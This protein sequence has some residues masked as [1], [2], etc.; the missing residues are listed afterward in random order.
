MIRIK[1]GP[2]CYV[3]LRQVDGGPGWLPGIHWQAELWS[4][5]IQ[6]GPAHPFAVVWLTDYRNAAVSG[7]GVMVNYAL[8][9][10]E[11]RRQGYA[12]RLLAALDRHYG[13]ELN[14]GEAISPEGEAL[15][16]SLTR[17]DSTAQNDSNA[18]IQS[19]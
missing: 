17:S 10:D 9:P 4:T 5:D 14:L 12:R 2:D 8:T 16:E 15:I 3:I 6:W 1:D 18:N 13:G 7:M 19:T 11:F